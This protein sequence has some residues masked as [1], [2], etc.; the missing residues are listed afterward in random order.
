MK[1]SSQKLNNQRDNLR[2]MVFWAT[3]ALHSVLATCDRL[4]TAASAENN[5]RLVGLG[6]N[7][8]LPGQPH[9]DD[10][11]H[12]MIEGHD[13]RTLHA[14]DNLSLNTPKK[15]LEGARIRI[16]GTPCLRCVKRNLLAHKVK[17]IR[18]AG[19]YHNARG[20]EFILQFCKDCQTPLIQEKIDWQELFQNLFD[21]MAKKGGILEREKYRLK[22]I[23]IKIK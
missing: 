5:K 11:G 18:Y 3:T 10:I 13:E 17:E 19:E 14:E 23:K 4:R 7:G 20:K 16:I 2:N 12:L 9:C 22:I 15:M 6:Y 1:K 8:S 21:L